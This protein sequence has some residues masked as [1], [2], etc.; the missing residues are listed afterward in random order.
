MR[1]EKRRR[2]AVHER[3]PLSGNLKT[4]S[5]A[6]VLLDDSI[7]EEGQF[8]ENQQFERDE[9]TACEQQP[10]TSRAM[11]HQ[12]VISSKPRTAKFKD[13]KNDDAPRNVSKLFSTSVLEG[14]STYIEESVAEEKERRKE[15][16]VRR[17]AILVWKRSCSQ[18][19]SPIPTYRRHSGTQAGSQREGFGD[20]CQIPRVEKPDWARGTPESER[21]KTDHDQTHVFAHQFKSPVRYSFKERDLRS[22][23]CP[24]RPSFQRHIAMIRNK[25]LPL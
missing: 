8:E 13:L 21:G 1:L 19:K 20:G 2:N 16:W 6:N 7:N 18:R 24:I 9:Q 12:L 23:K 5:A 17:T 4:L 14:V 25:A 3:E 15:N 10:A 22:N 11:V